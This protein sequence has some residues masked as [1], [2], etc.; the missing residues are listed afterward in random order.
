MDKMKRSVFQTIGPLSG[1]FDPFAMPYADDR[2]FS[3]TG[4][5]EST[6][7]VEKLGNRGTNKIP[8]PRE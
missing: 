8:H 5:L 7:I 2:Y 3:L 1:R 6:N 4:R